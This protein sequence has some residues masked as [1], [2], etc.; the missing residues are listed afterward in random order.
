MPDSVYLDNALNRRAV[1]FSEVVKRVAASYPVVH[2]SRSH[3]GL[4]IGLVCDYDEGFGGFIYRQFYEVTGR[5]D[6][7]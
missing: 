4:G 6:S 3:L 1:A 2:D 5:Y 7:R